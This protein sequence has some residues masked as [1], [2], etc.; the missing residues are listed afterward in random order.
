MIQIR[1]KAMTTFTIDVDSIKALAAKTLETV[2]SSD[3]QQCF[4]PMKLKMLSSIF[5]IS[6]ARREAAAKVV[7]RAGNAELTKP[8]LRFL[9]CHRD[10]QY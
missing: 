9:S 5:V 1:E 4:Q 6:V 7:N 8:S 3:I 2:S 10:P